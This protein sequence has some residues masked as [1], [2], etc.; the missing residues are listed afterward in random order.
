M[1]PKLALPVVSVE[2]AL[3]S[4]HK[5]LTVFGLSLV[6]TTVPAHAGE[7]GST[8]RGAVSISIIVPPHVHVTALPHP[9][10]YSRAGTHGLCITSNGLTDYRIA[11][12]GSDSMS[13]ESPPAAAFTDGS[14]A[15]VSPTVESQRFDQR[16]TSTT[17]TPSPVTLLIIPD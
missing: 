6:G 7:L 14:C 2:G 13:N 10:G 15:L 9:E 8:S 4:C 12:L 17:S 16:A 3:V 11:V 5:I 1:K